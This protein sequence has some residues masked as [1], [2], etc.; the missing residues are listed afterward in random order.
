MLFLGDMSI[1]DPECG[2][3][4]ISDMKSSGLFRNQTVIVNLE[5]V[6]QREN[7]KETFWKVYND[8]SAV[9]LKDVCGQIIFGLANNHTYDYPEQIQPM[10]STLE[11]EGIKYFGLTGENGGILPLEFEEDGVEYAVLGHCWEV[12]TKTNKNTKTEDRV[13]DCTYQ[14]F[15]KSVVMYM[16]SH[17]EKKV[18]CF[19][20]WNFDMEE[21]PFPAYKKLAHDLIDYGVEA[22]IGNHAHCKQEVEQYHG[23]VIAYGL[24]NFYMPDG[25]FF[26]GTLSYPQNSHKNVG[27]EI[28]AGGGITLHEFESDTP[29]GAAF[30]LIKTTVV[31][32]KNE[33]S[34]PESKFDEHAYEEFFRKNRIKRKLTPVFYSYDDGVGNRLKTAFCIWKINM[35][36]TVKQGRDKKRQR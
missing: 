32:R 35:I 1:P 33:M 29:D 12:Y 13:V 23:K 17:P 25:Y 10:L 9:M 3:R 30:K 16:N 34:H 27:I 6:L 14:D 36:R 21:Y 28:S 20:H 31:D 8:R 5:G 4:L 18:I 7:P 26:N 2:Q 24:G 15:Y 11:D 19:F 22:V